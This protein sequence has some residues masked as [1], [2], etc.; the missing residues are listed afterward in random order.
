MP[1]FTPFRKLADYDYGVK[2][3]EVRFQEMIEDY[4]AQSGIKGSWWEYYPG[5]IFYEI[6]ALYQKENEQKDH[7]LLCNLHEYYGKVT[8][9]VERRVQENNPV[10]REEN[11]LYAIKHGL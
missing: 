11:V 10:T 8:A 5:Q 9:E 1:K 2:G 7:M 3:F 4:L 6:L